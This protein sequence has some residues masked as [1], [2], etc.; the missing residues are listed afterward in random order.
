MQKQN[1][2]NLDQA[3]EY[4]QKVSGNWEEWQKHHK[5]LMQSIRIILTS[6]EGGNLKKQRRATN[7]QRRDKTSND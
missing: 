1:I 3:L 2:E 4:L 7:D 5:L 6:V